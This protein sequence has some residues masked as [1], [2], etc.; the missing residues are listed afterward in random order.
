MTKN[1]QINHGL[2]ICNEIN[3][4]KPYLTSLFGPVS[5]EKTYSVEHLVIIGKL[6][7]C[8]QIMA[9][10]CNS[11]ISMANTN[12]ELFV[13]FNNK[14]KQLFVDLNHE[15]V[16]NYLIKLLIRKYG[17]GC[18]K[19]VMSNDTLKWITPKEIIGDNL[20]KLKSLLTGDE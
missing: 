17:S 19:Y 18:I 1:E 6:K 14:M 5:N 4:S 3:E 12:P 15:T 2:S 16:F 9:M 13:A 11:Q 8:I 20:V 10:F 7:C